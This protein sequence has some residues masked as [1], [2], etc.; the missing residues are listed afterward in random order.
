M[1]AGRWAL[2]M[3]VAAVPSLLTL[4]CGTVPGKDPDEPARTGQLHIV[5][6]A[7]PFQFI[8][9][10]VAGGHASV[11]NLTRPGA[12]P[13]DVELTPRQVGSIEQASL[14]IFSRSFQPA[15]DQA[16]AQSGN[17]NVLDTTSVVPLKDHSREDD[18]GVANHHGSV[19]EGPDPHV[20][21]DPMNVVAIANAV[22]DRLAATDATHA[23][24]YRANATHLT[25]E[26]TDLDAEFHAG[27]ASC[28]RTEFITT[29]AAFGYLA[30]RYGLEQIAI[31]GL[32]PDAE[33][34]PSRIAEVQN[35]ARTHGITTIFFETL[36][37]PAVAEAVSGDLGLTTD[38]LDPV[39]G[40]TADSRGHDYLTIMAANLDALRKANS[41]R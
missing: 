19:D 16:V 35:Q 12:E 1:K 32:S 38:I 34:S 7:Y 40:I 39:E 9:E 29:H 28:D 37:S 11:S 21:L 22:A 17:P 41:C 30:D 3:A 20:W 5:T 24:D 31:T 13:H 23:S 2:A 4:G 25:R 8:A 10:R 14:V 27:L 15:V 26:L 18:D 36:V 33:P 6:A